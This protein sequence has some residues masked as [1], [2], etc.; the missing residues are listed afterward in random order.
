MFEP[1]GSQPVGQGEQKVVVVERTRSEGRQRLVHQGAMGGDLRRL[2]LEQFGPVGKDVELDV[3]SQVPLPEMG[4]G[5]DRGIDQGLV[6]GF[7]PGHTVA[8]PAPPVERAGVG[9]AGGKGDC[10]LDADPA[11]IV[12]G[13]IEAHRLPLEVEHFL[14]HHD[15]ALGRLQRR[16]EHEPRGDGHGAVG[17]LDVKGGDLDRIALPAQRLAVGGE[18]DACHL[19]DLRSRCVVARAPLRVEQGELAHPRNHGDRLGHPKGAA[20]GIGG[21]DVELHDPARVGG[22]DRVGHGIDHRNGHRS[23]AGDGLAGGKIGKG[24]QGDRGEQG[25]QG[26]RKHPHAG[27][28]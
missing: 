20:P 5:E 14:G 11:H 12:P 24:N 15:P 13:R 27:E 19:G 17:H 2:G 10:G 25:D 26:P 21:V 1:D 22:I 8:D 23:G 6:V 9:P 16:G 7:G 28:A 3:V 4:S 18:D